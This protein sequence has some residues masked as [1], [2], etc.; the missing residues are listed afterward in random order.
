MFVV[1]QLWVDFL[2]VSFLDDISIFGIDAV[3]KLTFSLCY[4]W[5]HCRWPVFS[6]AVCDCAAVKVSE[7]NDGQ[8][9]SDTDGQEGR[10]SP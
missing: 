6:T 1:L 5:F 3:C 10:P 2:S 7:I 8:H 9:H 4:L